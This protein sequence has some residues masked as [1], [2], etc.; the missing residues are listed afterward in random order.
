MA[1]EKQNLD[2][3][4]NTWQTG[5]IIT[6]EKLNNI[7]DGITALDAKDI[8]SVTVTVNAG[9]ED[10]PTATGKVENGVLTLTFTGLQGKQGDKGDKGDTGA[11][12]EQGPAGP[13]GAAGAKGEKGDKGDTGKDGTSFTKGVAVTH[14]TSDS[15]AAEAI[16]VL[17]NLLTSLE[18][19][20]VINKPTAS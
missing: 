4:E 6:A 11:K 12:G 5:D 13:T 20:G 19:A 18:N 9:H 1:D 17:N 8:D 2:Y 15:D 10:N 3:T 14:V 7:E 16:T